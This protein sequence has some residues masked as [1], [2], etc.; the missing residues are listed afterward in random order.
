MSKYLGADGVT[1]LWQK[2]K[3]YVANQ[4]PTKTSDLTNDSGFISTESDPVF[5]GSAAH[6]ISSSDISLGCE[7]IKRIRSNPSIS[8]TLRS[9]SGKSGS[10]SRSF[11]YEL[12]FCPKRV[13]SF[14]PL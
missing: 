2:I 1:F 10:P 12:T 6:G 3:A 4:V 5:R 11:P 14:T 9:S 7:V 8:L 13:I